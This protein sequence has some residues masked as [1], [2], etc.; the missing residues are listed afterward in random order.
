MLRGWLIGLLN[1]LGIPVVGAEEESLI[2]PILPGTTVADIDAWIIR[3]VP[4]IT[5]VSKYPRLAD[6]ISTHPTEV[7]FHP[8]G[9]FRD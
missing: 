3:N 1:W 9:I 7:D 4:W 8:F 6:W 5:D 2:L